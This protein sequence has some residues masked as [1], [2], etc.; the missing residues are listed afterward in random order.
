MEVSVREGHMAPVVFLADGT[1]VTNDVVVRLSGH[2]PWKKRLRFASR[3]SRKISRYL[4]LGSEY[5]QELS[6]WWVVVPADGV[7][8]FVGQ[9]PLPDDSS[10]DLVTAFCCEDSP[11]DVVVKELAS[12]LVG[13]GVGL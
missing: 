8:F 10:A 9:S 11:S 7:P 1:K 5:G 4:G 2:E 13:A 6:S 12:L 3:V